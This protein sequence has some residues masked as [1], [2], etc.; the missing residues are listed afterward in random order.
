M[1][2]FTNCLVSLFRRNIRFSNYKDL[3]HQF[4]KAGKAINPDFGDILQSDLMKS[5]SW[6]LFLLLLGFSCLSSMAHGQRTPAL[7]PAGPNRP[8]GVPAD[9]V[10]TPFG[11][12]HPSCVLQLDKRESLNKLGVLQRADGSQIQVGPCKYP[13]FTPTG[14]PRTPGGDTSNGGVEQVQ[15]PAVEPAISHSWIENSNTTT[16]RLTEKKSAPGRCRRRR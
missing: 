6:L 8:A 14:A 11:Y 16:S 9:Y 3:D 7:P 1:V 15:E 5:P 4:L 10:I 12:F 13:H 2:A